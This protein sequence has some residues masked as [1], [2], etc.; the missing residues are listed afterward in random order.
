MTHTDISWPLAA[1]LARREL[2][3][4]AQG[5]RIFVA[6]LALGVAAIAAVGSTRAML[7]D[8]IS[9]DA[10]E[11]LGLSRRARCNGFGGHRSRQRR[12]AGDGTGGKRT[13]GTHA[14]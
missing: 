7:E 11:I 2:R 6:C 4:G 12:D 9:S 1:R 8:S 3:G 14:R 13:G 10:R 5:F